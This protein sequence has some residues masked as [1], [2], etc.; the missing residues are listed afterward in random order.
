MNFYC[1]RGYFRWGKISRKY[2]QDVSRGGNF[3]DFTPSSFIK[4]YVFYFRVG[5]IFAKKTKSRKTRKLPPRENFHV[6]SIYLLRWKR[7][8]G[9]GA[10]VHVFVWQHIV[11]LNYRI[12]WWIF[13][14]LGRDKVFSH[15]RLRKPT[16]S[17]VLDRSIRDGDLARGIM[18][19]LVKVNR[20]MKLSLLALSH[21]VADHDVTTRTLF[22]PRRQSYVLPS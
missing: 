2:W 9:G 21:Y 1:K 13:T 6:Y 20:A 22:F 8:G 5:V 17:L 15:M 7:G 14:K 10:L 19:S 3:H 16:G 18:R 11:S 12:V 4:P